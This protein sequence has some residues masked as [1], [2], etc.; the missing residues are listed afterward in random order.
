MSGVLLIKDANGYA[1]A[2]ERMLE[3]LSK[4]KLGIGWGAW[5]HAKDYPNLR[6][7]AIAEKEGGPYV[8]YTQANVQNRS[9]PLTRDYYIY[10]NKPPGRPL[11]PKVRE[12]LRVTLSREGQQI[13]ADFG[14]YYP[15]PA[16]YIKEQLKKLD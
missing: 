9:Y 2:S 10:V 4:D 12:F 5:L 8:P 13:I 6:V 7:L 3:E 16:A 15:M 14:L 1:V 11:D